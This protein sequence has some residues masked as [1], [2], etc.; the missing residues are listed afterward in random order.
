VAEHSRQLRKIA[1]YVWPYRWRLGGAALLVFGIS[2]AEVAKPWP[3]KVVIDNVLGGAPLPWL[4]YPARLDRADLLLLAVFA[5]VGI[6][7]LLGLLSVVSNYVTIDVGQR[8]VNDFRSDLYQHLQRLSLRFH[9]R[10]SAGDLMYRLSADTFA[11]QTLAMNGFFPTVSALVMLVGMLG[12][13][14][15][16]DWYLTS[17]ALLVCP[18]LWVAIRSLSRGMVRVATTAREKESQ[19]YT[20]TQRAVSSIKVIQAFTTE[21]EEHRSFLD[22]SRAS[23]DANLRLYTVQTV[24][25]MLVNVIGALGTAA[26]IWVGARHVMEGRLSIGDLLIFTTYL[27]SL[28][29]PINTISNTWGLVQ[30][31]KVG[32]G[33][34]F[35]ILETESD[36]PDGHRVLSRAEVRG[37][38]SFENVDFEYV[39][40]QPVLRDVKFEVA[41]GETIAVVGPTGAGKTTLVSLIAR[42]YDPARGRVLLDGTDLR[43]FELRSL[44][45]QIAMVLQP[46]LVF[47]TTLRDNIAYGQRDATPGAIE[48]AARSAQLEGLIGKLPD[49]LDTTIGEKG[50]TLSEGECQRLTIARALLREAPIL[51]LDE[52]T[53]ALDAETEALLMS[54]LERLMKG[55]TSFVIAHRLST[56]RRATRILVLR[57]G[58]VAE[59]GTFAELI[60]RRGDFASLYEKQFGVSP[61]MSMH[62]A[63]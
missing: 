40:G 16:L 47:P 44:R 43:T 27:A 14:L 25:S 9:V 33:R 53:S 54:S 36:V 4:S 62:A 15:R 39:A 30:G 1:P 23:L 48:A 22:V 38:I 10:R 17:L 37:R 21:E 31:A 61:G 34:V 18:L 26:V 20:V 3:L 7:V 51:I 35:E 45:R 55:R 5:L 46:P 41:A 42:F 13:M 2:A 6:Y 50:A 63:T 32:I 56:V 8:M 29:A 28:Y 57:D 12:V 58:R 49:G 19:L 59:L 52:P 60:A 24:Y 11:I